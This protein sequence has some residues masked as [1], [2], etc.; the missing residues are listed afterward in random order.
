MGKWLRGLGGVAFI[1]AI[2]F[3]MSG[4]VW[5]HS[6]AP[7]P[8]FLENKAGPYTLTVLADPDVGVGTFYIMGISNTGPPLAHDLEV[9]VEVWPEDG[10][11]SPSAYM[12]RYEMTRDGGRYVAY[13]PFDA[14][15]NW[16]VRIH[17]QGEEGE[18]ALTT[19]VRVTPPGISWI[20]SLLCFVPFLGLGGLWIF[21]ALRKTR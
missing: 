13:V 9:T 18:G 19:T 17:V 16:V 21:A 20:G 10:H 11:A 7:Y 6:G 5:A 15:G 3:A 2:L 1:F 8:I 14:E 4:R 12:A